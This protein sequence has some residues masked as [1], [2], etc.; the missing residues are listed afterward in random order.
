MKDF[1]PQP[2]QLEFARALMTLVESRNESGAPDASADLWTDL[3][4]IG[5]LGLCGQEG[6]G[7]PRDFV[8][9]MEALGRA[10]C[11]GPILATT[12]AALLLDRSQ[13]EELNAGQLR[14]TFT[15]G[16]HIPW[17]DN[18]NVLIEVQSG[19]AWL[20]HDPGAVTAVVTLSAESWAVGSPARGRQLD[21][22]ARALI[23]FD[24]GVSAY[25]VGCA[26]RLID[27]GAEHARLRTQFGHFIGDFQAVAH[28]L[29]SALAQINAT[30]YLVNLAAFE[31][32]S[33]LCDPSRARLVRMASTKAALVAATTV[34]QVMG[35]LGFAIETG[36]GMVSTRIR[37]WSLLP[38]APNVF[39]FGEVLDLPDTTGET[40]GAVV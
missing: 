37:Q 23:L 22:P 12:A 13:L 14:V 27:Q 16:V 7:G 19:Q 4:E 30:G 29:A 17:A 2:E 9:A 38:P 1:A 24:L 3:A 8:V 10:V 15:D 32:D 28:S 25:L 11:P 6:G 31:M 36:V 39:T 5:L 34:H 26:R 21:D 33:G 18:S 40:R 35:G 20:I